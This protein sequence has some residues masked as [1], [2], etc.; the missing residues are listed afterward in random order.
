MRKIMKRI[1][2][3]IITITVA[4]LC[5]KLADAVLISQVYPNPLQ[6]FGSEAVELYNPDSKS[7]N[8]TGFTIKTPTSD[9]DA[10]LKGVIPPYG[11][12]LVADSQWHIKRDNPSWPL[13]DYEEALTLSNKNSEV[14]LVNNTEILDS[15]FWKTTEEGFSLLRINNNFTIAPPNFRSS[16]SSLIS[17]TESTNTS[18]ETEADVKIKILNSPPN[19]TIT[20][21]IGEKINII[22]TI[23]DP[24]SLRDIKYINLYSKTLGLNKTFSEIKENLTI[25]SALKSGK[26]NL[27]LTLKDSEA[28]TVINKTINVKNKVSYK[29]YS[30]LNIEALANSH[31]KT[32]LVVENTGDKNLSIWLQANISI[33]EVNFTFKDRSGTIAEK[34]MVVSNLLPETGAK[35]E[36][37]LRTK[38]N[39]PIGE[40]R[41][42]IKVTAKVV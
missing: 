11:Y 23:S 38:N 40:Y 20:A 10:T 13:A 26:H 3:R 22:I 36:L 17:S 18:A 8:I 9:K 12:F 1:I 41:G 29:I 5:L 25:A 19:G 42:L 2:T 7:V 16:T 30:D 6:E 4:L 34:T 14:S 24:N 33:A 31:A 28:R 27:S 39:I 35:I 15:V 21:L 32:S 37:G